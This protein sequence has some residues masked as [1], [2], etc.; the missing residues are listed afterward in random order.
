MTA[1]AFDRSKFQGTK[2]NKLQ[3]QQQEAK[4]TDVRLLGGGNSGGRVNYHSI[5]MGRNEFRIAPPHNPEDLSYYPVR[6]AML[7]CE[8]P[9]YEDG[10]ETGETEI[11]KKKIFIA[12]VHG[13]KELRELRKDPI[14][15]YIQYIS[16]LTGE[17]Q[18]KDE[19]QKFLTPVKGWRDKKGNWNWGIMPSTSFACYAWKG[20]E[21]GRLELYESYMNQM[22]QITGTM[23]E[24]AGELFEF[25]IFSNPDEG[26]SLI[27][28][29]KDEYDEKSKKNKTVTTISEGK[30]N[31][32][33]SWDDFFKRTRVTDAQLQE[34]SEK[35]SLKDMFV[36]CYSKRD[37]DL[38]VDGLK[39]FDEKYKFGIFNDKEYLDELK[40][41]EA[42]VP[43]PKQKEKGDDVKEAFENKK[44]PEFT[45][46]KAKKLLKA[47]IED[48]YPDQQDEY[49]EALNNL[50]EAELKD[51][52]NL[53]LEDE[54]LPELGEQVEEVEEDEV[55]AP[56]GA[57]VEEVE[58]EE[59]SELEKL[60]IARRSRKK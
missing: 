45:R 1:K 22:N 44:T 51:W 31:R 56:E 12:T 24:E 5:E 21:L 6:T 3:E 37:F 16:K 26:Y 7:E 41:I 27:I 19:R 25:D 48:N 20:N 2:L 4:K 49:N 30:M 50:S 15:L 35:E 11:K 32:G 54:E 8:V 40:E 47:Y 34:L 52:Y 39:R 9:K 60:R 38:A 28:T 59:V 43:E 18:D 29:K 46:I 36:D 13:N 23:E 14:E 55:E 42:L 58:T 53:A 33:E 10:K 17:I 57:E